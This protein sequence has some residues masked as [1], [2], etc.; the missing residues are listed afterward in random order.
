M[1]EMKKPDMLG[2]KAD[3]KWKD[4]GSWATELCVQ[5]CYSIEC[6]SDVL[7]SVSTAKWAA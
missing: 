5:P 4:L 1:C 7:C 3:Q 6:L 2:K